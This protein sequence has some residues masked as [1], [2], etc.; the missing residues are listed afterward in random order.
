M[1]RLN[2]HPAPGPRLCAACRATRL[3]RYNPDGLCGP[4][5]RAVRPASVPPGAGRARSEWVPRWVWDS[6]P[7]RDALARADMGAVMTIIRAASGLSQL[8]LAEILDCSQ[9]TIWRIEA[10]ERKSLHDIRELL[11]FADKLGMPRQALVPL[12]LSS[13]DAPRGIRPELP[14]PDA[15]PPGGTAPPASPLP[16]GAAYLR[17]CA[18]RL[19]DLDHA[20]GGA[21]MR[22]QALGLWELAR[23]TLDDAVL[24]GQAGSE[25]ASAA[26]ELA[27]RAGWACF[28]GGDPGTARRMYAEA[29]ALAHQADDSALAAQA[30]VTASLLMA[31][32][33]RPGM[34][35]QAAA[36]AER[37]SAQARREPWPRLHALIEAREAL[38]LACLGNGDAFRAATA[39]AWREIEHAAGHDQPAWLNFVRPAEIAVHE[40]RGLARLGD[41]AGAVLLLRDALNDEQVAPR[42][43]A[44]YRARLAA[45]LVMHGDGE[46]AMAEAVTVLAELEGSILSPRTLAA[47]QPVRAMAEEA[48]TGDIC[49]RFDALAC[50]GMHSPDPSWP[51]GGPALAV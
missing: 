48:G 12:L 39:R 8:Q 22:D 37:A 43:R 10:G 11:R 30:L 3:S 7:L 21:G 32:S 5:L 2:G 26:G 1:T 16:A 40:A 31:D 4:C 33:G 42:N 9:T 27:V 51:P 23:R 35:S 20:T 47:L 19:L 50:P 38:A 13:P 24:Q 34:A 6:P 17:A 18:L 41:H 28:D 29:L 14:A 45:A 25:L 15:W 46:G 49:A 44:I 36:L